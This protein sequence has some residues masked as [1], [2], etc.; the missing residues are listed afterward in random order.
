MQMIQSRPQSPPALP[1]VISVSLG[2]LLSGLLRWDLWP[3]FSGGTG[4]A[5]PQGNLGVKN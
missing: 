1:Q 5:L 2:V 3:L 4:S